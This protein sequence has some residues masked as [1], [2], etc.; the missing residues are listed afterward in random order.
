MGANIGSKASLICIVT[1]NLQKQFHAGK[2]VNKVAELIGGKGGGRPDM[3]MAGG[4][5]VGKIKD[6]IAKLPEIVENI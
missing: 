3:A 6:A 1:P 5:D 2:I 4:K